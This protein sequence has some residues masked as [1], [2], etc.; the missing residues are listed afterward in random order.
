MT[1][2]R[3]LWVSLFFFTVILWAV[4]A[5]KKALSQQCCIVPD[6]ESASAAGVY[7]NTAT[8]FNQTISDSGGDSFD[9]LTVLESS[10]GSGTNSCWWN[11]SGLQQYP[12]VSG[13]S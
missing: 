8:Q 10:G 1:H 13:G 12:T 9:A 3:I 6:Y 11:G 5:P 7:L 2:T 4:I